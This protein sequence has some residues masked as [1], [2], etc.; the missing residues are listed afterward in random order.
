MQTTTIFDFNNN[1]KLTN[2]TVIDDVVMGGRSDGIFEVNV[3]GNGMFHGS[4]SL[5]NNGGFSS[6]RY[7]RE[8]MNVDGFSKFVIRIKGD[9]KNYQFRVKTNASDYHSYVFTFIANPGWQTID[10]PFNEM[11]PAYRGRRLDKPNYP[12]KGFEELGFLI[13]NKVPENFK[14]EIDNIKLQ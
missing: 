3:D 6:I 9:G 5:E 12:G 4:V 13:G 1:T 14:L 2:W 7:A 10:I 8:R 11:T